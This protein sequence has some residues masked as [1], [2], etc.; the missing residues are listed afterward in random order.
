MPEDPPPGT[1]VTVLSGGVGGARFLQGLLQH[2]ATHDPAAQ[3]TVVANT[4]DDIWLHGLKV[5]PDLDTVMYTLGG[6]IDAGRGWGRTDETWHAK[7]E[8]AAY[9]VEPTWFGLGDRDLA[10]HLVRTQ[11]LEAGYPL[12]AVT[13][14]L[15]KRWQPGVTLLPMSDDRVETHVVIDD[16]G[17]PSGRRAV[18]FQEYWVRLHAEVP[19]HAVVPVGLDQATP[20]PGVVEAITGADLVLVPPSNPV[21]SVGTILGVAGIREALRATTAPV[22]GL[23]PIVAG[24]HVRGM[25]A[26]M[27]T[28]LGIEVSAA[29]VAEHYGARSGGGVVDAWL[30]DEADADAVERVEAAGIRCRAVPLMMTDLDATAAMVDEAYALAG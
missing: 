27:L 3:V 18:H 15:C 16:A 11:M 30:V 26:Q 20:A 21:V 8:L 5:C 24:S 25:A 22:V 4:A 9:G 23:S 10:T 12:S 29:A 19:A 13:A 14:A 2:L 28:A 1:R 6:G 17:E 7:E